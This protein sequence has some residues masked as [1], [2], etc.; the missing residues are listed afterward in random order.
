MFYPI[1]WISCPQCRQ[2]VGI[3]EFYNYRCP[4]CGADL[5]EAKKEFDKMLED[6]MKELL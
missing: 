6:K 1:E 5:R 2:T 3:I 4:Y